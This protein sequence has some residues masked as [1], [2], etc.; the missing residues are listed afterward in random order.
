M[1]LLCC[2]EGGLVGH[3]AWHRLREPEVVLALDPLQLLEVDEEAGPVE[4]GDQERT[5]F[6][7][8]QLRDVGARCRGAL[9]HCIFDVLQALDMLLLEAALEEPEAPI[10]RKLC[11]PWWHK[12]QGHFLMKPNHH[13]PGK[14]EQDKP[15]LILPGAVVTV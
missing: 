10:G 11:M 2:C 8:H 12:V 5:I 14:I 7:S 4:G 6:Q 13:P 3:P 15:V 9:L 1:P